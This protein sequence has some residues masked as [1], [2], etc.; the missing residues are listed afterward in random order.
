MF[1]VVFSDANNQLD[2]DIIGCE[3]SNLRKFW[4]MMQKNILYTTGK[5]ETAETYRL[6]QGRT[7]LYF[8]FFLRPAA[9]V[10]P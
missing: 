4:S 6:H 2:R 8:N 1:T 10:V 5:I 7:R 9:T 3:D